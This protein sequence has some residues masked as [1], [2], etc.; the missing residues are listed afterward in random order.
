VEGAGLLLPQ[1]SEP[2]MPLIV[3]STVPLLLPFD[4]AL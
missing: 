1:S 2:L 4:A 3:K